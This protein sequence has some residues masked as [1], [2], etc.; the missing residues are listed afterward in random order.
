VSADR[1]YARDA[2][3]RFDDLVAAERWHFWFRARRDLVLWALDRYLPGTQRLLEVGCGAGF[4]LEGFERRGCLLT[5]AAC[6]ASLDAIG[7]ARRRA[8][9]ALLFQAD[10]R[11]LPVRAGFDAIAALDVI[12]HVHEDTDALREMFNV[13]RP[14]G[15]L[16]LTVPQHRWLWSQVDEFSHH[17]RR[18][19]RTDLLSKAHA[20]GFEV[21]RCTSY[22]LATLPFAVASRRR[23]QD[24]ATFDPA[25]ELRMS[26]ALSA[27]FGMLLKP[28]SWLL[29][30]GVPL[31]VG[32]SLLLVA[33]RP[34]S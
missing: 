25:A 31:P 3:Y 4:V 29:K 13:L 19:D 18:Y 26:K 21:I 14:G 2:E 17:C 32:S 7:Y 23:T 22:F 20:A 9:Q 8:R 1:S 33:R 6:D 12:E 15:G 24:E 28:E 11:R 16:L 30:A 10:V 5:L 34:A 27:A